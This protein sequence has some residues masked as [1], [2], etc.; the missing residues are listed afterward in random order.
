MSKKL[1]SLM[2]AVLMSLSLVMVACG[3]DDEAEEHSAREG[4][5]FELVQLADG[6]SIRPLEGDAEPEDYRNLLI[7]GFDDGLVPR[8]TLF[9]GQSW[10]IDLNENPYFRSLLELVGL[11]APRNILRA[12]LF[13]M[14]KNIARISLRWKTAGTL[15]N[16][17]PIVFELNGELHVDIEARLVSQ[18]SLAGGKTDS[19]GN[20]L[21]QISIQIKREQV[22]GW[23]R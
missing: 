7:V 8:S 1:L 11:S 10:E 20:P 16:G 5:Q 4:C 9:K 3:G 22:S 2:L 14:N 21:Q 15:E 12:Q 18:V 6:V 23:Y 13:D 17:Q 19:D